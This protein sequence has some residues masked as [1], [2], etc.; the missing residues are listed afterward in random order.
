MNEIPSKEELENSKRW[1]KSLTPKG[2]LSWYIKW[3]SSVILL[4]AMTIRSGQQFPEI[5]LLLSTIGCA[6]WLIV[7]LLW[8]DRALIIL[9]AVAVVILAGGT[10]QYFLGAS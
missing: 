9:N 4:V 6:G 10:L 1:Y 3:V 7:G 5:D 8:K 2:D